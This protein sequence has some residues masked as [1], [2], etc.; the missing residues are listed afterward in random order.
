MMLKLE[1]QR[2]NPFRIGDRPIMLHAYPHRPSGQREYGSAVDSLGMDVNVDV[3]RAD[4]VSRERSKFAQLS[5]C[6]VSLITDG[7]KRGKGNA[8]RKASEY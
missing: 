1:I 5:Q 8:D 3:S 2:E 7:R 4:V 6:D